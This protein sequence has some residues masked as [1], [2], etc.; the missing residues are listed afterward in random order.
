MFKRLDLTVEIFKPGNILFV[1]IMIDFKVS[2][3]KI[4]K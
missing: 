3:S 4:V 1:K 2:G